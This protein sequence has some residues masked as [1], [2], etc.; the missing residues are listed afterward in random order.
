MR[1]QVLAGSPGPA[2]ANMIFDVA[3]LSPSGILLSSENSMASKIQ[4]GQRVK[5]II[6][7][8]GYF[9]IQIHMEGLVCRISEDMAVES[10]NVVR[11]FGIK[12]L[13]VNEADRIAFLEL[14]KDILERMK[15]QNKKPQ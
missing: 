11:S 1:T 10:G 12:F 3:N 8:R 4:P 6:E 13:R 2:P 7:P 5:M 14:L 15:E 9:P